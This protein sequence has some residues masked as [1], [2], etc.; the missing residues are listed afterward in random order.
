[1]IGLILFNELPIWK[2]LTIDSA[3]RTITIEKTRRTNLRML[4]A[5]L[6]KGPRKV[7]PLKLDTRSKAKSSACLSRGSPSGTIFKIY[8][9]LRLH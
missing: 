3:S 2:L 8:R 1:V 7:W 4:Y 9:K 6:G 5:N